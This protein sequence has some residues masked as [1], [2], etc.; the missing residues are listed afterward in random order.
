MPISRKQ[1][2][3]NDLI[4]DLRGKEINEIRHRFEYKSKEIKE[5]IDWAAYNQAQ[6]EE[7]DNQLI[8]IKNMVDDAAK[9]IAVQIDPAGREGKPPKNAADKA[10]A[11]LIQQYFMASDRLAAGLAWFLRVR[12]K[13]GIKEKLAPKD[14]ERAYDNSDVIAILME[15]FAMTNEPLRAKETKF[16]IDG[17][18]MPRSIKQN[19][20]NDKSDEK[21]KAAYDMLVGMIG[22]STKMFTSFDIAGPGSEC[23]YL[24]ALL[25]E[26]SERYGRIE[27]VVA[28]AEFLSR[29]NC[30]AIADVGAVPYIFPKVGITL[31]QGGSVAWKRMLLSL[32]DDPQEWLEEYHKRS[33]D[34]TV[35]SV[36]KRKYTRPLSR[37]IKD[38]R[39]VEVFARVVCFNIRRLSYLHYLWDEKI[40]WLL[41][42]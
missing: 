2:Q 3:L 38:R 5:N 25:K 11:V 18:G 29:E 32:I 14:I 6:I 15:L 13:L 30:S 19:Y 1:Q 24:P 35:N 41:A 26:T 33:I 42:G 16:G 40:E 10:K 17:S 28:D 27:A 9:R 22:L 20:E 4:A 36:W 31:N 37:E 21:K 23:R 12:E 8:L 39:K 7:I 34:E